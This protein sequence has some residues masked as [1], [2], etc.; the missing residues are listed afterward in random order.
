MEPV[1]GRS[2]LLPQIDQNAIWYRLVQIGYSGPC[3]I[4]RC[5]TWQRHGIGESNM[6]VTVTVDVIWPLNAL[7]LIRFSLA[8]IRT[9][10]LEASYIAIVTPTA[11][12]FFY[13]VKCQ[14]IITE[15]QTKALIL[16]SFDNDSPGP[17][18]GD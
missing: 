1:S 11:G 17:R 4:G 10:W 16:S 15:K 14:Q 2:S 5:N 13:A 3:C 9:C 18:T 7:F 12:Y 8:T 6:H